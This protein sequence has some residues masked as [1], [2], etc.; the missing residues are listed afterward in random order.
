[1]SDKEVI[2]ERNDVNPSHLAVDW[3]G[4]TA[5]K[6]REEYGPYLCGLG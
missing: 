3:W 2:T 6:V 4:S 5:G 1:M